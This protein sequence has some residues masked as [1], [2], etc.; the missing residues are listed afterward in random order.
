M[1]TRF[2]PY[3]P[4]QMLL[5]PQDI[6]E[7][8]P[9][10]HLAHH[11]SDLVDGMDL[12]VFYAPYAGD[13]RRN[14]PYDPSMMVKVLIYAY[15]S[16]VFCSR[17]IA[18][19]LHEDV[20]FRLLAAGNFPS[21]RTVCEFR[22]RHLSDFKNLFV[23]VLRVAGEMGVVKFGK[24]SIDGTKV[25][26]NASKRKAMSYGGL[27]KEQERLKKEIAA[28]VNQSLETDGREDE[29]Y[30]E[31][32]A[33]DELPDELSRRER[34][35]AAI[36]QAKQRLEARQRELDDAKGRKPGQDRNPQGG[37]PYKRAYGEPEDK[38]QRNFTDPQSSIMKTST[39]GFQQCYNAQLAV[40]GQSQL[41]VATQVTANGSDQGQMLPV[42]EQAKTNVGENPETV[43]ADAGYANERDLQALESAGVDGYVALGRGEQTAVGGGSERTGPGADATEA[44]Y[45][46]RSKPIC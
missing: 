28:R 41:I 27:K 17:A 34:R 12:S 26:A 8:L 2:R 14:M 6:R 20:A 44:E 1:S 16:G 19:R 22:R 13:G 30:G 25:R 33:G 10:N 11:I 32:N 38:A 37:R 7:W 35:L 39:E 21:H 23:Q 40:E 31:S 15:A 43:L 5:L 9:D 46:A 42:L 4:D 29:R 18:R 3:S 24:I 45:G 36:E